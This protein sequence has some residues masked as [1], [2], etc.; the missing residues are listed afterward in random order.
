M[1]RNW[2]DDETLGA[3][4]DGEL[5]PGRRDQVEAWLGANPDAAGEVEATRRLLRLW[6]A[7]PPPEPSPAAWD[8]TLERI[9]AAVPAGPPSRRRGAH[10][11]LRFMTGLLA[12]AALWGGLLL[13]RPWWAPRPLTVEEAQGGARPAPLLAKDDGE[14]DGPFEV[15]AA[16]DVNII[17]MDARD[18]DAVVVGA[19]LMEPFEVARP[20]DIH[21]LG[22]QASRTDGK[23]P[24][25]EAGGVPMIVASEGGRPQ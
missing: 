20:A 9:H 11:P 1:T 13:A 25:L 5:P 21:V 8:T 23:V 2:I 24:R 4:A 14:P 15:I 3:Y 7:N 17:R 16:E 6:R 10:W 18:A 22:V 12:A 19:P